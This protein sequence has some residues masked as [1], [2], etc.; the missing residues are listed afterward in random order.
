[1]VMLIALLVFVVSTN[2]KVV[3][4]E[5]ELVSYTAVESASRTP[6]PPTTSKGT[7]FTGCPFS[8]YFEDEAQSLGL[9]I[10]LTEKPTGCAY[11]RV[12]MEFLSQIHGNTT[13]PEGDP[14]WA[15]YGKTRYRDDI[16]LAGVNYTVSDELLSIMLF[17][18]NSQATAVFFP[19]IVGSFPAGPIGPG[20]ITMTN[21]TLDSK[22][23]VKMRSITHAL[24]YFADVDMFTT[25]ETDY[26]ITLFLKDL[27]DRGFNNTE[28]KRYIQSLSKKKVMRRYRDKIQ[29][30]VTGTVNSM[31][32]YKKPVLSS[33][34]SHLVDFFMDVH[35]GTAPHPPFVKQWFYNFSYVVSSWNPAQPLRNASLISGHVNAEGVREYY[36]ERAKIVLNEGLTDTFLWAWL[37]AGMSVET[38]VTEAIHN[39]IAFRQFINMMH[40]IMVQNIS[41]GPATGGAKYFQ[42]FR[43][44]T[45]ETQKI[46]FIR[47]VLRA[48]LPNNAWFSRDASVIPSFKRAIHLPALIQFTASGS[49][50]ATGA[51]NMNRYG[52]QF[53]ATFSD[54][55]DFESVSPTHYPGY[56]AED[57]PDAI[58]EAMKQTTVSPVDGE[59]VINEGESNMIPVF[60]NPIYA[61][62]G[63]GY[64]RCPG[65]V[66][67]MFIALEIFEQMKCLEF[68]VTPGSGPW[69][70]VPLAPLKFANDNYF[71]NQTALL[72]GSP[73]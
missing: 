49:N 73:C 70:Q 43:T 16:G 8:N 21:N 23:W 50:P 3:L 68:E 18:L 4:L 26:R 33:F 34:D 20:P 56:S 57:K 53:D 64:R 6:P 15:I 38:A 58:R 60:T 59:T 35:V 10:P 36:R 61:A 46:N 5:E 63:L 72:V 42:I 2:N 71:V 1:M 47:E 44:L 65:E 55:L 12:V 45:T 14:E 27:E 7:T 29:R 41:P 17:D 28:K 31:T 24:G 22:R 69:L 40:L 9:S 62:F 32:I 30:F 66:I 67:S 11:D 25:N 54:A 13:G 19:S 52:S 39:I 51:F 48:E 37:Q